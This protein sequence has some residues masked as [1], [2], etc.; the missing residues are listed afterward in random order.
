MGRVIHNSVIL[1]HGAF[2]DGSSWSKVIP[3]LRKYGL[4]VAA[5]Q[6]PLTSLA[7]DVRTVRRA[8][9]AFPGAALLVGHAWGGTVITEA[10]TDD[11]VVGLV[12]LAAAAPDSGESF[13]DWLSAYPPSPGMAEVVP[14]GGDS[15]LCLTDCGMR[16]YYAQDLSPSQAGLLE[17]TQ[18]PI[19][20]RC[21]DDKITIAAWR[22]KLCWYMVAENDQML[23]P[24]A[25]RDA[26]GRMSAIRVDVASGHAVMISTPDSV[27]RLIVEAIRILNPESL[28]C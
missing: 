7:D 10:G 5:V 1:V 4:E 22:G 2:A 11:K 15:F 18:G 28:E 16:Y 25:E 17:S 14:Y 24:D 19:A 23:P 20:A 13:N 21:L 26:A 12:Y 8:L 3:L 27:A 9:K 6:L